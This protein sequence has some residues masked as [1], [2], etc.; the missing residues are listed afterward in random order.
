MR[1]FSGEVFLGWVLGYG[2]MRP[3]IE[4]YRGDDDRGSV[5]TLSTSQFIGLGLGGGGSWA[6]RLPDQTLPG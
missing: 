3:I 4:I 6:A 5:G 2:I 1:K